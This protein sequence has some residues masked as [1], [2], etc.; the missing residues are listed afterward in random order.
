MVERIRLY[1]SNL[2]RLIGLSGRKS[3]TVTAYNRVTEQ[4]EEVHLGIYQSMKLKISGFVK[5]DE[6]RYDGWSGKLPF[7]VYSCRSNKEKVFLLGYPE[8]YTETLR[9]SI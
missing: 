1:K 2:E 4:M 8:G 9:C 6:R 3:G 5:V 7:Y